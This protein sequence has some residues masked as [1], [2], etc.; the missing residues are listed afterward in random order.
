MAQSGEITDVAVAAGGK[1]TA[2]AAAI[3]QFQKANIMAQ[4]I[5]MQAAPQ[6]NAV[7]RFPVYTKWS[8]GTVDP[9]MSA[10]AE[11]AD[12]ALTDVET[13]AVDVTPIR[14]G[15]YAQITDLSSFV[16]ADA[17]MVHAGQLLGNQLARVFDEKI[18]ALFDGFSNTS[19]LTTDLIRMDQIWGAVASLEQN[20][21]PKPYHCV[22]HPLQMWGGFGLSKELGSG[23]ASIV[24]D[25][26]HGS[27]NTASNPV[28]D[29]YY[30][31]GVV[32]KLGPITFYTS[33]A[34]NATSDQHIGAMFSSDAIGCGYIDL[35]GG[36][37]IE[38][39]SGRDEPAALTE[40]V[41]NAYF[42]SSELVDVYGVEIKTETS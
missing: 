35:G 24:A 13:T 14:Y 22:L 30:N 15:L 7:V 38:I 1:G 21:A 40:L 5:T 42:A 17:V 36:S 4:C 29:Q 18:A 32:T 2:V 28:S 23:T 31:N 16:N 12:A 39:K 25:V 6:G 27:L 11:G 41:G 3:V 8:S 19:N 9:T 20:D 34:V 10:N 33:S 26:S 37:M